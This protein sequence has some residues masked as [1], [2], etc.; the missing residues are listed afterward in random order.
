[1]WEAPHDT[2]A[3]IAWARR[4][5]AALE[6]HVTGGAY[7]NIKRRLGGADPEA[8]ARPDVPGR[9]ARAMHDAGPEAVRTVLVEAM[10][11]FEDPRTGAVSM[12]NTFRWLVG[13]RSSPTVTR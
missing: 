10:R 13:T 3:E 1:M 8:W 2:E 12:A 5:Y 6:P 7:V 9:G 11:H 4:T